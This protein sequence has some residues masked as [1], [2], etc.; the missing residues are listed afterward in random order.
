M[1]RKGQKR[2]LRGEQSNEEEIQR[3]RA[4][5]QAVEE[6]LEEQQRLRQEANTTISLLNAGSYYTT[7]NDLWNIQYMPFQKGHLDNLSRRNPN[8]T[9]I[10]RGNIAYY[11][12]TVVYAEKDEYIAADANT[13]E[14]SG[15][16]NRDRRTWPQHVLEAQTV[17]NH[18][19]EAGGSSI[20][21]DPQGKEDSDLVCDETLYASK[22]NNQADYSL[23]SLPC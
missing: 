18:S 14:R 11:V 2:R 13:Q 10:V 4:R 22:S 16:T 23:H 15:S 3:L 12:Q 7:Y 6:A 19:E 9:R 20:V 21:A 8:F 17:D 1:T 5:L